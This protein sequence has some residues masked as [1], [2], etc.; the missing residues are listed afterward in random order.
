MKDIKRDDIRKIFAG[1]SQ[2]A[3][4]HAN[5]VLALI[6]S[7]FNRAISWDLVT[8]ENP[9]KGI[10]RNKETSRERTVNS[11]ELPYLF[12]SLDVDKNE[13]L[14]DF[15]FVALFTGAR[16]SNVLGMKW[17]DIDLDSSSWKIGM[18]KNGTPQT[19]P[20]IPE[21]MELLKQR[22]Q[23]IASE[24]VF[25]SHGATGHYVESK[26]GWK[27]VLERATA[28]RLIEKIGAH[29]KWTEQEKWRALAMI[30]TSPASALR[31]YHPVA[32]SLK[33]ELKP[34]DMRDIRVHD[35]RRTLGSWQADKNVSLA[36]IGRTLNHLSPQST[37]I[38]ARLS[39][40]PIRQAM[41]TATTAM[42]QHRSIT[43]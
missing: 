29:V 9:C 38:Y 23:T 30:E 24:W 16:R 28:Y 37:K 34:L 21:L 32:A 41:E 26:R 25:P 19:V 2:H 33:I 27:T 7:V 42:L 43:N 20:L 17:E 18:T 3:P 10:S 12:K 4:I 36:I 22:R 35:L 14:R 13:T 15:V 40:D 39:L 5:R 6:R 1:V 31:E 11:H 8:A